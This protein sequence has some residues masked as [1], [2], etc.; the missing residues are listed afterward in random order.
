MDH[1]DRHRMA[2]FNQRVSGAYTHTNRHPFTH[3]LP[4]S[5]RSTHGYGLAIHLAR[6]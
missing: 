6:R 4:I 1:T 2:T 5:N 3:P